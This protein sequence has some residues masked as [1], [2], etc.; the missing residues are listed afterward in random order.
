MDKLNGV[1]FVSPSKQ[2]F[3]APRLNKVTHDEP[4]Q[5]ATPKPKLI[6][7]FDNYR[8][9]RLDCDTLED[10]AELKAEILSATHLSQKQKILL[11]T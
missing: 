4:P 7:S 10:W 3:D 8:E 2:S 9:L 5:W 11:T 6:R 1:A